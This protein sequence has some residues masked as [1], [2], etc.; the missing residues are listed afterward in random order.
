YA[1]NNVIQAS[2]AV[3]GDVDGDRLLEVVF[4]TYDPDNGNTGPVG[5]W[6]LEHDGT[7][8]GGH[9]LS[10]EAPGIVAPPQLTDFDQDGKLEIVAANRKGWIYVW[11]TPAAIDLN[12]LPWPMGRHDAHRTGRYGNEALLSFNKS[13]NR[14]SA[15]EGETLTYTIQLQRNFDPITGTVQI[16]DTIP[17]HLSFKSG[18]LIAS[19]GTPDESQAPILRWVGN[20]SD[21]ATVELTYVVTVPTNQTVAVANTSEADIDGSPIV[22]STFTVILNPEMAH[23]PVIFKSP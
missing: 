6:I 3:V 4:G 10:V 18:S 5:I 8:K 2:E 19:S 17:N 14:V 12:L 9:P 16:E 15:E 11:D 22:S 20:L 23:L 21:T 13:A 7:P 1:Q